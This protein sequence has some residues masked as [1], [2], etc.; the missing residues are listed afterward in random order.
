V[1]DIDLGWYGQCMAR[2]K[3]GS[4]HRATLEGKLEAAAREDADKEIAKATVQ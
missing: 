2:L 4:C 3:P 1:G